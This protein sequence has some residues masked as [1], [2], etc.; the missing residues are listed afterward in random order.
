MDVNYLVFWGV[1]GMVIEICFTAARDLIQKK[2]LNL[3]G[4]T[5]LWMFPVYALGLSYG[6][7]FVINLVETDIV[8]YL[9]Y[10]F[11]IWAVELMIGIPALYFRLR[12]WDYSYLPKWLHWRGIIS[13]AHYP[14]WA[15]FGILVELIK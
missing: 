1:F 10:P 14:L 13:F 9:T 2:Q 8:R 7:D 12:L 4:H 6:F 3:M 5:S 15:G 11:W